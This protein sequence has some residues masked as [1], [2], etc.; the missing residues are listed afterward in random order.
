MLED[1]V[2][3]LAALREDQKERLER[4]VRYYTGK[5][6]HLRVSCGDI[7]ALE[8]TIIANDQLITILEKKIQ[9]WS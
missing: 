1:Y 9:N 8:R 6:G 7:V 5:A 4:L 3:T 2:F